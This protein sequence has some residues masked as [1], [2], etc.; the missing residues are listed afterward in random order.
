MSPTIIGLIGHQGVGKNYIAEKVLPDILPQE[1]TVV[2]AF[3]D[4]FK[5]DCI[6]KYNADYDKVY[7]K[8]KILFLWIWIRRLLRGM[9][10]QR[11]IEIDLLQFQSPSLLCLKSG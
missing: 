8:D 9:V 4:H 1:N 11:Y 2:L 7:M 6:T 3:A 5:I 10:K